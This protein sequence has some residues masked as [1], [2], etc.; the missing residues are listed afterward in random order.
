[1]AVSYD[2]AT[3]RT[4]DIGSVFSRAF[5]IIGRNIGPYAI[6]GIVLMLVPAAASNFLTYSAVS[7]QDFGSL[8][9]AAWA[10]YA[11]AVITSLLFIPAA[12][13]IAA[14]DDRGGGVDL[15]SVFRTALITFI[16]AFLHGILWTIGVGI[17]FV[18]I[19]IPGI[20]LSCMWA[21]SY[22]ALVIDRHGI[23]GSFGRSRQL[24]KGSRWT[25]FAI[26]VILFI[27]A[28]IMS[29]LAALTGPGLGVFTGL[30]ELQ[31][32]GALFFIASALSN[33][34]IYIIGI[35][36][37]AAMYLELRT[38]KDGAGTEHLGEVFA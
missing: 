19:I 4:L 15:G 35:A 9:A 7:S 33:T 2:G 27:L 22:P 37:L 3:A 10:V 18:L 36:I 17:G 34:I 14:Q 28:I 30:P 31:D 11:L 26:L 6:I 8:G 29:G 32:A 23:F 25:I 16:P 12:L 1:M 13:S 20:I 21:V 38:I 24:T 5:G